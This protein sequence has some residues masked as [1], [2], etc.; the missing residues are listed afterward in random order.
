M[1]WKKII[2]ISASFFLILVSA[3][4]LPGGPAA[5]RGSDQDPTAAIQT[6]VAGIVAST[7]AAQ[8][9][10]SNAVAS[11]LAA[12]A[13]NTPEFT[14]T[15]SLTFTPSFT[16]TPTFTLTPSV[17]TVSVSVETNCRTGP[18]TVYDK[19]GILPVGKTADV[20]GRSASSDN[21]IIKLPSNPA[22]TCWL[23]G[24]YATLVGDTSG[25]PVII[26]P[27]TP[28]PAASFNVV[29]TSTGACIFATYAIKFQITNTGSLTWE[30]NR[31]IALDQVTSE[32]KE[33]SWDD[34][35]NFND[36]GCALDSTD[37]NLDAGEVGHTSSMAFSANPAGHNFTATI[38]VCSLDGMAGICLEKTITFTP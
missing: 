34:F 1:F 22:I 32:T 25:L 6:Q 23:W 5:V 21:W 24:K 7:E 12:M 38:K 28:T 11:T 29:Y 26:P 20:V 16:L 30:S 27:P 17:P 37:P 15:P 33:Y 18:G 36:F 31:V 13:T 14:F 9:A 35:P 4:N 19:L 2:A 8:T 10:L 3:C